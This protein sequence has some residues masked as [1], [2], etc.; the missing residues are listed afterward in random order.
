MVKMKYSHSR[1]DTNL[2]E[3]WLKLEL[4]ESEGKTYEAEGEQ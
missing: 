2:D 1:G 3:I 4:N